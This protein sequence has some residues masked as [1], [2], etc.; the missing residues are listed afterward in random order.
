MFGSIRFE[1]FPTTESFSDGVV[2]PIPKAPR[3]VV[4][5]RLVMLEINKLVDVALVE[6]TEVKKALVEVML[7][8]EAPFNLRPLET[9]KLVEVILVPLRLAKLKRPEKL[10][11]V[12]VA[13]EK[14][15][16]VLVTLVALRLEIVEEEIVVV[17]K[18]VRPEM[19][20]LVLVTEE[21]AAPSN[22]TR[23]LENILVLVTL[24]PVEPFKTREP[25][26]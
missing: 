19:F 12:P 8:P 23:P 7:L 17:L 10:P 14:I 6:E 18:T 11:L 3:M 4:V 20:K 24:D 2:V 25:E 15:I 13:L 21:P 5:P 1:I 26:A 22:L 9:Y 16:L